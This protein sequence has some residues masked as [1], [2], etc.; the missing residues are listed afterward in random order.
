MSDTHVTRPK[1]AGPWILG[2]CMGLLGLA[3]LIM[4]SGTREDGLYAIGLILFLVNTLAIFVL[5][6]RLVGRP[7]DPHASH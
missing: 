5:I 4:A 7:H 3:G 1:G 2:L 6:G